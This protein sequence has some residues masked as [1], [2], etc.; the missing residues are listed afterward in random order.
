M[1]KNTLSLF[2]FLFL[3]A[4]TIGTAQETTKKIEFNLDFEKTSPRKPMPDNWYKWGTYTVTKDTKAH[5]GSYAGKV[6]SKNEEGSFGCITHNIPAVYAGTSISL[7]G[8]MKTKDVEGYAGLLLRID[9]NGEVLEFD[10]M[11]KQK[12]NGTTDWTKYTVTLNYSEEAETIFVAGILSGKGEA[13]FDDF[14]VTIDGKDIQTIKESEQRIYKATLDTAFDTGS[15]VKFPT[16]TET[17]ITDLE[18]LGKVWGFLK[19]HHPEIGKGN[20]NWDYDLFR[21]LPSFLNVKTT[22]ER[23]QLL[24]DWIAKLGT[25]A[26]C[27]SCKQTDEKA[28]LKP[29]MAW[30]E[31]LNL[32][33]DL[34]EKLRYIY[35]N[36]FQGRHYYVKSVPYVEN[37][38]FTNENK[39][40]TMKYPDAGFRLLTLYRYWNMIHYYFPY[41]HLSDKDWGT[42]LREYIPQ[43]VN[44]AN[45]LEFELA[46]L[47][48]IGDLQDTHANLYRGNDQFQQML[49]LNTSAFKVSFVENKLVV[50]KYHNPE[51]KD[52]SKVKV[53]DII[54]HINGKTVAELKKERFKYHPASNAPTSDRNIASSILRSP[55]KE[56]EITFVSDGNTQTH[57][58]PLYPYKNLDLYKESTEVCY[59]FINKDIGYVTLENIQAEDVPEIKR[60]F[61]NTKGIIIDIRNYPSTFVPYSLGSYFVSK[62]SDFAKFT[63][64]NPKNP[65]EFTMSKPISIPKD[66]ETYSGKLIVLV[67]EDSQSQAEFTAMAFDS[68]DNTTIVGSTTAGA[69]GNVSYINLPGGLSTGISG[70]GVYYP[71]GRE[72]QRIGIVPDVIVKPTIKGIQDGRD[73]VLEKAIQLIRKEK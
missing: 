71:D 42:V 13:W 2:L 38:K 51:F 65:G 57:M 22:A 8:Y 40:E 41:K 56:I 17:K 48:V 9:G 70:I 59:K 27:K 49:G 29:D 33:A 45:E 66:V 72:T 1:M 62:A 35:N 53:G 50:I 64:M 19:Y 3:F 67:N 10:N 15:N 52:V 60:L 31:Q 37:P 20:Y 34:K 58:L 23:D 24:L 4:I 14:V 61:K 44:A 55:E 11:K 73:E 43:F 5:S 21:V 36:R 18:V 7:T 30:M 39:Y 69:D 68:G 6:A 16:L 28:I 46:A 63:T 54:T 32:G 26:K 12:I 25:V 47:Y